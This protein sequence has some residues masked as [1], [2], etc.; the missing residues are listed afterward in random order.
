VNTVIVTGAN[1][2][3][4][5]EMCSSARRKPPVARRRRLPQRRRGRAAT[6]RLRDP[7]IGSDLRE[8]SAAIVKLM[9]SETI[10]TLKSPTSAS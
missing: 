1:T 6:E 2:G 3:L 9:R 8:S 7:A 10:L 5:S 4:G